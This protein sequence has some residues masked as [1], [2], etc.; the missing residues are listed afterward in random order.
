MARPFKNEVSSIHPS[1][2]CDPKPH[3][4]GRENR[5]MQPSD[6][7]QMASY[8]HPQPVHWSSA[9][10]LEKPHGHDQASFN[11]PS[12]TQGSR[13]Q[14]YPERSSSLFPYHHDSSLP[15]SDPYL[16][17]FDLSESR[18]QTSPSMM[19]M[20]S[21]ER[22]PQYVQVQNTRTTGDQ[23]LIPTSMRENTVHQGLSSEVYNSSEPLASQFP[24][25]YHGNVDTSWSS[26]ENSSYQAQYPAFSAQG[27]HSIDQNSYT[28]M[29]DYRLYP[30]EGQ[31]EERISSG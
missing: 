2:V 12:M 30:I 19:E 14:H 27:R 8:E 15:T 10:L 26:D 6:S 7:A 18:G 13:L 23:Q 3:F 17:R 1:L 28:T 11:R 31:Y 24:L 4:S 22:H 25:S 20:T 16:Y 5:Q 21:Y 29:G 9:S